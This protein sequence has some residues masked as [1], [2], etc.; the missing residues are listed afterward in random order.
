[1]NISIDIRKDWIAA[2]RSVLNFWDLQKEPSTLRVGKGTQLFDMINIIFFSNAR[3]EVIVDVG[4]IANFNKHFPSHWFCS[5][6][7]ESFGDPPQ[8]WQLRDPQGQCG[9]KR[10]TRDRRQLP[11]QLRAAHPPCTCGSCPLTPFHSR[12]I[13]SKRKKHLSAR[14]VRC[15][16]W[17]LRPLVPVAQP[18]PVLVPAALHLVEWWRFVQYIES[19]ETFFP[20]TQK[21]L[22]WSSTWSKMANNS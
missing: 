2:L 11:C 12:W 21:V 15:V 17:I 10:R 13:I 16:A 4:E 14:A 20:R 18:L 5:T 8:D 7:R 19:S 9:T 1:M 6:I 22:L 3:M